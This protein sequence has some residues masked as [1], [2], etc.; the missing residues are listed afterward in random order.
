MS[1]ADGAGRVIGSLRS[2]PGGYSARRSAYD[3]LG[4]LVSQ[5]NPA[6]V[7]VGGSDPWNVALWQPAG[8]DATSA[9]GT[10]WVYT[11]REYDWKG[12]PTRITNP[13]SPA[14]T[15]EFL[16][17]G[18][19]CAG[20]EV[21]TTRDEAG[22]RRR[23]TY[24]WL[25][26]VWKMQALTQ[27][28]DKPQPFT[29]DGSEPAYSTVTTTY[30]ALDRPT[31]VSERA[32][33]NGVERVT[34]LSYDGHGR[35]RS[36]HTPGQDA[37]ASTSYTYYPDDE[38]QTV[39]D[40]RGV[41]STFGYN[42]RHLPTTVGFN[43]LGLR[44][45]QSA[46]E[47]GDVA[48]GYDAA[49]NRTH[50]SDGAG[51][52]TYH[53]DALS[54][55]DWEERQFAGLAGAFRLGYEYNLAG[56]VKR[57]TDRFGAAVEY[58]YDDAGR[59]E[60]VGADGDAVKYASGIKYRAWGAPSS[61]TYGNNALV[62]AGYDG[63]MRLKSYQVESRP[64]QFAHSTAMRSEYGYYAD[65]RVRFAD[66]GV[67][68]RFDRAYDYDLAGRLREAYSGAQA[69]DF[70]ATGAANPLSGGPYRVSYQYDEFDGLRRRE[71]R[72]WGGRQ[73]STPTLEAGTGRNQA[74]GYDADGRL[75]GDTAV[76]YTYDAAG[77][78]R[79][80]RALD[81]SKAFL[82]WADGDGRVSRREE[83]TPVGGAAQKTYYLRSTVLGGAVAE[84]LNAG[85]GRV[86][87]Y[88]HLGGRALAER[89]GN[90]VTWLH[91]NPVTG[92]LGRSYA[93]GTYETTAEP[94]AEGIN[95]GVEDPAGGGGGPYSPEPWMPSVG[96]A[97]G[98]GAPQCTMD[99][100]LL[101]DCELVRNLLASGAARQCPDNDCGVRRRDGGWQVVRLTENGFFENIGRRRPTLKQMTPE[102]R[103]RAHR[104]VS[105]WGQNPF[106]DATDEGSDFDPSGLGFGG[107]QARPQDTQDHT[108]PGRGNPEK[109]REPT[110][111]PF[112]V[113]NASSLVGLKC[114][115]NGD[116]V[117]LVQTPI[118]IM[119]QSH[120]GLPH[121]SNWR[122]GVRVR[123]NSS[124]ERGT[125][126][127]TFKDGRYPPDVPLG[128]KHAAIYDGQTQEGI[129]V[130]DQYRPLTAIQRRLIKF[131]EAR[132]P[133]NNGNRFS[134]VMTDCTPRK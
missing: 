31:Q 116:C 106:G 40:G 75:T 61:I 74:W 84:E 124:I 63:R 54:R 53:Y 56:E 12:R 59:V 58:G 64:A 25:G 121:T 100:M 91:T 88:V 15:E 11:T 80:V 95:L 17:G 67:D 4:R 105:L 19:G 36:R 104:I 99:G 69:R 111:G 32:E 24:D 73:T 115:G 117:P 14:T 96:N 85:G 108:F 82:V 34:T 130:I 89:A 35:L 30:D 1:V 101:P 42:G 33:S 125:V 20:G 37:G 38:V 60:K 6:E 71:S 21:V 48:F 49:G 78:T 77:Q 57:V 109:E 46:E 107:G 123:G 119:G 79:R 5:S 112:V 94:D 28:P 51:A 113:P 9:G 114:V 87:T 66:D 47:T 131:D 52:T 81:G 72:Y 50:M 16:Y 133:S 76:A 39:T 110:C 126:I 127:A 134:V 129:W 86:K 8:E 23:V 68:D 92:G 13:G 102:E 22:R 55:L 97:T 18:C 90:L 3:R 103:A 98:P 128:H 26:R 120:P 10:G 132:T 41:K 62:T 65:G 7:S 27:Q 122:E 93:D 29:A 44:E 118:E 2:L 83:E 43:L 45:G 70:A